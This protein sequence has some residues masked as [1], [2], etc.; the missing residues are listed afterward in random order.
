VDLCEN[1][2]EIDE[3]HKFKNFLTFDQTLYF[4]FDSLTAAFMKVTVFWDVMS[5]MDIH[6][7]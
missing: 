2:A 3:F 1:G 7:G 6:W 4:E 5:C